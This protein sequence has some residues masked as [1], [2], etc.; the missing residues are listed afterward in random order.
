[1]VGAAS[2]R[3]RAG[4][5][6][7]LA[8]AP[9]LAYAIRFEGLAWAP[10]DTHTALVYAPLSVALKLAT[11]LPFGMY[12]RLWRHASIPDL[13]KILEA[14]A[15]ASAVCGA[16]GAIALPATGLSALR[17]PISVLILDGFFNITAVA[18]SR[19]L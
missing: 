18:T 14:T 17:V 19:L 12:T 5:A 10:A 2:N 11:F 3:A 16:L 9:F 4:R 13:V 7:L 8:V 1:M 15:V 6:W